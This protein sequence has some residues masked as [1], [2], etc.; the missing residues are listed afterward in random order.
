MMPYF[1]EMSYN[2]N[3]LL[4]LVVRLNVWF[5]NLKL[6]VTGTGK[7]LQGQS[8]EFSIESENV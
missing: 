1:P 8:R 5:N 7:T 2:K 3:T 4:V 6:Y